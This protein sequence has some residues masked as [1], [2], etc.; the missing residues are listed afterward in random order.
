MPDPAGQPGS[1]AKQDRS[2]TTSPTTVVAQVLGET[3][4]APVVQQAVLARTGGQSTTK[5]GIAIGLLGFGAGL[6]FL[7]RRKTA[8]A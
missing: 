8:G 1:P 4:E 2:P 3:L 7:G 6:V 5:A